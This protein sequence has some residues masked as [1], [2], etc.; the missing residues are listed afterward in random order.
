MVIAPSTTI[1]PAP[2]RGSSHPQSRRRL[3]WVARGGERRKAQG[4]F[5]EI[6]ER[7]GMIKHD[8]PHMRREPQSTDAEHDRGVVKRPVNK[9][10]RL[11]GTIRERR[12][13][14]RATKQVPDLV[15]AMKAN[16]DYRHW[17]GLSEPS[18]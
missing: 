11:R 1:E 3:A 6:R 4:C 2:H 8:L 15:L 14:E 5:L 9:P 12:D 16:E 10:I 17:L 13:M 18:F 7:V